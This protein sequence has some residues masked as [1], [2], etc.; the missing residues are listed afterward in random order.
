MDQAAMVARLKEMG[1]G[2]MRT[3]KAHSPVTP[4]MGLA[5][6]ARTWNTNSVP[7][8]RSSAASPA[9]NNENV[10]PAA[11]PAPSAA[12]LATTSTHTDKAFG[13]T[14]GASLNGSAMTSPSLTR[15]SLAGTAVAGNTNT[16]TAFG[17]AWP[18]FTP[19][20]MAAA[21]DFQSTATPS[22]S[23]SRP[24]RA[25]PPPRPT[26]AASTSALRAPIGPTAARGNGFTASNTTGLHEPTTYSQTGSFQAP[27][28]SPRVAPSTSFGSG[29][30]ERR[31]YGST[32]DRHA[33]AS[34]T[35]ASGSS[36]LHGRPR[37]A[38]P[39]SA[40]SSWSNFAANP[41]EPKPQSAASAAPQS[42]TT[43]VATAKAA[44]P[45]ED[46]AIKE[47]TEAFKG[48]SMKHKEDR[49]DSLANGDKARTTRQVAG[50]NNILSDRAKDAM[51]NGKAAGRISTPLAG[52]SNGNAVASHSGSTQAVE[53]KKN[54]FKV[55]A[56]D[57]SSP[58]TSKKPSIPTQLEAL[59]ATRPSSA[60]P[61]PTTN[62]VDAAI[63]AHAATVSQTQHV[64]AKGAEPQQHAATQ[65]KESEPAAYH[66]TTNGE[67]VKRKGKAP[68]YTQ[69][70]PT[71]TTNGAG[72][73]PHV[74]TS[75]GD[76][77]HR[78][79]SPEQVEQVAAPYKLEIAGL[80]RKIIAL[81]H[82]TEMLR[83]DAGKVQGDLLW[84]QGKLDTL[85]A[86]E[87]NRMT[88]GTDNPNFLV[89]VDTPHGPKQI[90]VSKTMNVYD[91]IR[92]ICAHC[93]LLPALLSD[94]RI[95]VNGVQV[96]H[97][98]LLGEVGLVDQTAD[99]KFTYGS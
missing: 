4:P 73:Y 93:R 57:T 69:N 92:R 9:N 27:A 60:R 54:E 34:E 21:R 2:M 40:V 74:T 29:E 14:R 87:T 53:V 91:L 95:S 41:I 88:M 66:A 90:Q 58:P 96:G 99:V 89:N 55:P 84:V 42:E 38:P 17:S 22:G 98:A 7:A 28:A 12:S 85:I 81:E 3:N 24:G 43:R 52:A 25:Q 65:P 33:Q 20:Q 46:P 63:S 51:S 45:K 72:T 36:L 76:S 59:A 71:F 6:P 35:T 68:V 13:E 62:D 19:Q 94:C 50:I 49:T 70:T 30:R 44:E 67:T 23:K 56:T 75:N 39:S 15:S 16:N 78:H 86:G 26:S 48:L 61:P 77:I 31:P 5:A 82:K 64:Q 80:E 11:S 1:A 79:M 18:T 10:K 83:L 8:T 97:I 32:S 47:T 37:V